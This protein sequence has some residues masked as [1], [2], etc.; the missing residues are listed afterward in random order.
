MHANKYQTINPKLAFEDKSVCLSPGYD[1]IVWDFYMYTYQRCHF[2][3]SFTLK[4]KNNLHLI[5]R[6]IQYS[7]LLCV[8]RL[9]IPAFWCE[10]NIQ[11]KTD[12][13]F[14]LQI[15][16]FSNI[17]SKK[18]HMHT[19]SRRVSFF[20]SVKC[21]SGQKAGS[22]YIIHINTIVMINSFYFPMKDMNLLIFL[23]TRFTLFR[24]H[25]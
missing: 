7:V 23:K 11:V 3:S 12:V 17:R 19:Y 24:G 21:S 5:L 8:E 15:K 14:I 1:S 20:V 25:K 2:K 22:L 16:S 18:E 9:H 6:R 4:M 13:C 10:K